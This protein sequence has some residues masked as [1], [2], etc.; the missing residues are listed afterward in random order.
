M[1]AP[2]VAGVVALL[3]QTNP[4]LTPAQV[5]EILTS[6]ADDMLTPGHDINSGHGMVNV[7]RALEAAHQLLVAAP[8]E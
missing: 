4:Q 5:S 6:T 2:H 3:L 7:P 8:V 1:A